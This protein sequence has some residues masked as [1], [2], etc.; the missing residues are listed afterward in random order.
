MAAGQ[1][2]TAGGASAVLIDDAEALGGHYYKELPHH[3]SYTEPKRISKK[4]RQFHRLKQSIAQCGA[5][6]LHFW[7]NQIYV[8][9]EC[10][11]SGNRLQ[12]IFRRCDRGAPGASCSQPYPGSR[13]L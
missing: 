7:R 3:C 6:T 5:E 4:E 8:Q 11:S 2:A 12:F 13:G 1:V 10:R 9:W